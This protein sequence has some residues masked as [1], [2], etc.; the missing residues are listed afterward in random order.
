MGEPATPVD[1]DHFEICKP[2]ARSDLVYRK[3]LQLV[4]EV[5]EFSRDEQSA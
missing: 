5:L 3:T 2:R 4:V 1:A